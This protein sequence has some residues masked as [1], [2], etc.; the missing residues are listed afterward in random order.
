[1]LASYATERSVFL[2][3]ASQIT[4]LA[5]RV[6]VGVYF[7]PFVE[8]RDKVSMDGIILSLTALCNL[9]STELSSR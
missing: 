2:V 3:L 4:G 6:G 8:W 9:C 7:N 5:D 1:M